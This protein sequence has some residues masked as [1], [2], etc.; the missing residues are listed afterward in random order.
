MTDDAAFT[1]GR[2]LAITPGTVVFE[3]DLFQLIQYAPATPK[4]AQR[5]LVIVPPC[6]NK[7][8]VLDL[9]PQNSF[10]RFAVEQGITVFMMSW[11]NVGPDLGHLTWDDY[12]ERGVL[13]ALQVAQEICAMEQ[14]NA[15]GFCVGGTMLS[16][17]LA[18]AK[19]RRADPVKALTLL[20]TLLDFS[21]AGELG[22]LVDDATLRR[23][24]MSIG[25]GGIF[26]GR[27][28][29][30]V[31]SSLRP[32]ELIWQYVVGNYLKGGAPPAFDLLYWN[33]DSTNLPGPFLVWYLRNLYLENKLRQSGKLESCGAKVNLGRVNLPVFVLASRE[34]HIVPWRGAFISDGL[35]GGD[36]TFVLAA[37]GHIAGVI[38]PP[39]ANKRSHWIGD[40]GQTDP[41]AWLSEATE[42]AGSWW[43]RWSAWLKRF[44]GRQVAAP[45][46]IG[47]EVYRAIEPAPGRYVLEKA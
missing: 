3:N 39:A 40:V 14:V 22:C 1:V 27:E 44:G 7:F 33:S 12:I 20:T 17:A 30:A 28:F 26:P 15:L 36:T 46:Q 37:S 2:N 24:E 34:D 42:V 16:S 45:R 8:Y 21:Q 23:R 10:V 31:F 19:A 6:I 13:K 18:I 29:A 41:D 5:P 47:N 25:Q 4:V 35:L 38:N 43:P 32:N 11:R 9:Q